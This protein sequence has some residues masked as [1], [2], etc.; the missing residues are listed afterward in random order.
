MEGSERERERK[1]HKIRALDK[2]ARIISCLSYE[3]P[4]NGN[5]N[6]K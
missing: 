2:I 3:N 1:V 6:E 4:V 5:G